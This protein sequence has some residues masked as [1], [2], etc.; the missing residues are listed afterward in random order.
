MNCQAKSKPHAVGIR[1]AVRS[2]CSPAS[3]GIIVANP[4]PCWLP[5]VADR[6]I[7]PYPRNA[8]DPNT[9][10]AEQST[11]MSKDLEGFVEDRSQ[12]G[13]DRAT[14]NPTTFVVFDLWL[15][16]AH[17]VHLPIDV[18]PSQRQ[19]FGRCPKPT[20]ATQSQD[21]APDWIGLLH[22]LVEHFPREKADPLAFHSMN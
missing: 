20:V 7:D 17:P 3:N 14:T 12:L 5:I 15:W 1:A 4:M 8:A 11:T 19:H 16:D 6:S 9:M 21:H 22:Q 18:I 13:E 10:I 2:V